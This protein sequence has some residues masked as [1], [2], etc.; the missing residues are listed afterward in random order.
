[1]FF[2][3][4]S[5][6]NSTLRQ[7]DIDGSNLDSNLFIISLSAFVITLLPDYIFIADTSLKIIEMCLVTLTKTVEKC[8][9]VYYSMSG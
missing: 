6:N 4:L 7:D 3:E 9:I 5:K 8:E 2:R 1:M